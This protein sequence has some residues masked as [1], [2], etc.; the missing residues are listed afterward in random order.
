MNN[1]RSK[2]IFYISIVCVLASVTV[3][4]G[5]LKIIEK[6]STHIATLT[7][8]LRSENGREQRLRSMR[9]LL[10]DTAGDRAAIENYL[11]GSEATA[12]FVTTLE[13]Y[14]ALGGLD[15]E[16]NLVDIDNANQKENSSFEL[17]KISMKTEGSWVNNMLFLA[18]LE[19]L[20]YKI[21]FT[22]V[23]IEKVSAID[24]NK[25]GSNSKTVTQVS[26]RQNVDMVVLKKK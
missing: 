4:V 18:R 13:Q 2:I 20:P 7:T 8:D 5:L 23:L 10:A 3:C 24:P 9:A 21:D 22:R 26:W 12:D 1:Y 6:K 15:V 14:A 17:L 19:T 11:V 16:T 25:Q